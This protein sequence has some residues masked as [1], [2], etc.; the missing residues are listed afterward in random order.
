MLEESSNHSTRKEL[1]D[2]HE[3]EDRSDSQVR[4]YNQNI[5]TFKT[6]SQSQMIDGVKVIFYYLYFYLNIF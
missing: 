4:A 1:F 2:H 5:I 6:I 3:F